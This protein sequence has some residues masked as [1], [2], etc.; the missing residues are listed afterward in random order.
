MLSPH[1]YPQLLGHLS[2]ISPLELKPE[3]LRYFHRAKRDVSYLI[4]MMCPGLLSV[5]YGGVCLQLMQI[6]LGTHPSVV[7]QYPAHFVITMW[8]PGQ[9]LQ[10]LEK[11]GFGS[12]NENGLHGVYCKSN[13]CF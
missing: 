6:G 2:L 12:L 11:G 13:K 5:S 4:I 10:Q 7:H 9:R 1:P 3:L 8:S